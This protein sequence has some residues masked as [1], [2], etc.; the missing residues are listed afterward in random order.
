MGARRTA[1]TLLSSG[2]EMLVAT[3]RVKAEKRADFGD[4][5]EAAL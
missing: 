3:R 5:L 1:G 4:M 2:Q